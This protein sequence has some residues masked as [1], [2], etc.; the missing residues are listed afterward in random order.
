MSTPQTRISICSGVPLHPD[1]NHT[2]WF[3]TVAKQNSYFAG[4]VVKT[5]SAY[6]YQRRSWT[7]KVEATMEQAR[8]WNYLYFTNGASKTFYYF[9]TNIEYINDNTVELFLEMD[10]LQT[11]HFDYTL[12]PC[13]VEREHSETDEPGD[14]LI[15]EGLE[16]G[17]LINDNYKIVSLDDLCIL[18]L[19]SIDPVQS[20]VQELTNPINISGRYV[21]KVFSGLGVYCQNSEGAQAMA[22]MLQQL[23]SKGWGDSILAMWM[24]PMELV[25]TE[26]PPGSGWKAVKV[27][28]S[29]TKYEIY[30][31]PDTVNGYSPRNKKLL[32]YPYQMLYVTGHAG[33]G[34][35]F[36]YEW[37]DDP[38]DCWFAVCGAISP[39]SPIHMYPLNYK[40][41]GSNFEE[42]V[43]GITF[44]SCGWAS[45][46]YKMWLAQNENKQN[47]GYAAGGLS[48]VGGLGTLIGSMWT[49]GMSAMTGVGMI[50]G[51][52]GTISNMLAQKKDMEIQPPQSKGSHSPSVAVAQQQH[53]FKV[54]SKCIT[55]ERARILDDYFDMYGYKTMR[56]KVPNRKVREN[57]TY[58]KTVNC[59]ITGNMCN[60]DI[61]KIQ[62]IYDKGL[63]F[64]V[65]PDSI[66]SYH[67]TNECTGG[68]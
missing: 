47:F 19:T 13:F 30:S 35:P 3:D 21:D 46:V 20:L 27:T 57:W 61:L 23:D 22:G 60:E 8:T 40:K 32:T 54:V 2:I 16:V 10:V 42:G 65:D 62:S 50:A 36:R 45:D 56:V 51:G 11:Y 31:R 52:V 17:D 58:T 38:T 44:P 48:I 7:V 18:M 14:N 15:E 4:K 12:R 67:L 24:Y 53:N 39:N 43:Q 25:K 1:Y 26:N 34:A 41:I 64:W 6:S 5:F 33:T 68:E 59:N 9:I 49:G 29:K 28:G 37:F 55:Q 63:T 66:G